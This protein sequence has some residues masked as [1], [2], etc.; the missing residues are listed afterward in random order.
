MK[1]LAILKD[2]VREA[3][4]TKVFYVM[5]GLSALTVLV[6]ASVSFAPV[7]PKDAMQVW[8]GQAFENPYA[9]GPARAEFE[10]RFETTYTVKEAEPEG[11]GDRAAASAYRV[12]ILSRW[13]NPAPAKVDQAGEKP[14]GKPAKVEPPKINPDSAWAP[15]RQVQRH[16]Q[17]LKARFANFGGLRAV[18]LTVIRTLAP[19]QVEATHSSVSFEMN[20][21]R[22]EN[23]SQLWPYQP[24]LFF[25]LVPLTGIRAPLGVQ[26]HFIESLLLLG[27]GAWV[28][29]LISIVITA[30]F[31][32]NMLRRGSVDLLLVKPIHRAT[33]L[34]Y[35]YVG[36][37]SF[38]FLN[39]LFVV[40]G[41]W[42]IIGLRTGIWLPNLLLLIPLLT[43]F[44][45]ILYSVSVLI[46]V[47]TRSTIVAIL[48]TVGVWFLFWAVGRAYVFF[49][50][51]PVMADAG[52]MD[53]SIGEGWWVS[54]VNA[55]HF[56]LPRTTD[57]DILSDEIISTGLVRPEQTGGRASE[58]LAVN[59][60]ES[61][62][63]SLAFI[64]V[65][66]GL[67]CWRFVTRDY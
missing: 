36:G 11:G 9:K 27:V 67:A 12:V 55:I 29:I 6:L 48:A 53:R 47:L 39:T 16:E 4:D 63:V 57:L 19:V 46:G 25:G 20:V 49:K 1:Y 43:F 3:I 2:C 56:V 58:L 59:W 8:S 5:V 41:V 35:K 15:E 61:L 18:E 26:I 51:V 17:L 66:L 7:D 45:A 24:T 40:G 22:T 10:R 23:T 60:G 28:A 14:D 42:I 65:M 31:I 50:V 13:L 30:F 62:S 44:F 38:M 37:L 32:P 34:V 33:L 64:A 54:V 52:I 21:R